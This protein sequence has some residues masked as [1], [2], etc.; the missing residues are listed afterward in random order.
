MLPEEVLGPRRVLPAPAEPL[1][2]FPRM[3]I[4]CAAHLG[5]RF[6]LRRTL[7]FPQRRACGISGWDVSD[8]PDGARSSRSGR[9]QL[10]LSRQA[11]ATLTSR[12]FRSTRRSIGCL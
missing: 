1:T 7:R 8:H 2:R 6:L 11:D 4:Y 5:S 12:L 10:K 3:G 9:T